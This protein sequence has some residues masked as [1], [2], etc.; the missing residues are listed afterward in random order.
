MFNIRKDRSIQKKFTNIGK[1][2]ICKHKLIAR[3]SRISKNTKVKSHQE[4]I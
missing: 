1:Q 4:R 3:E 2:K